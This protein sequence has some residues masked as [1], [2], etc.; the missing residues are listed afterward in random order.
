MNKKN[1]RGIVYSTNPDFRYE[2][3]ES[4]TETMPAALQKLYVGLDSKGRKGKTV[5]LVKGFTGT[6]KDAE[7][8]AKELK[9]LCGAGGSVKDGEIMIQ[10]NFR[11]KIIQYLAA[12]GFKVKKAGG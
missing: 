6:A 7:A 1:R 12:K 5:S 2:Q 8:L 9:T 10:G 3:A 11:E 4:E